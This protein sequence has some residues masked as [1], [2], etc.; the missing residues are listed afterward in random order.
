MALSDL[1]L[2]Q[3]ASRNKILNAILHDKAIVITQIYTLSQYVSFLLG[4]PNIC[5]KCS[6]VFNFKLGTGIVNTRHSF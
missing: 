4:W 3:P 6:I 2:I 5:L 1:L